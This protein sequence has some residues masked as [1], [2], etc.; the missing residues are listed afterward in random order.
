MNA[1]TSR[2]P[3]FTVVLPDAQKP[4]ICLYEE[5]SIDI[6]GDGAHLPFDVIDANGNAGVGMHDLTTGELHFFLNDDA[7]VVVK[8]DAIAWTGTSVMVDED[9]LEIRPSDD[10]FPDGWIVLYAAWFHT[11][12]RVNWYAQMRIAADC[13][14]A[15]PVEIDEDEAY[16]QMNDPERRALALAYAA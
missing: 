11:T 7:H 8:A 9:D 13:D 10:T 6:A 15:E 2:A 16:E 12:A 3:F 5:T 4:T 14:D 1:Q